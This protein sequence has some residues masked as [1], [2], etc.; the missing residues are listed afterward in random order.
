MAE[1]IYLMCFQNLR[2]FYDARDMPEAVH[3]EEIDR[4][5]EFTHVTIRRLN[6][7][8]R[9]RRTFQGILMG[10]IANMKQF[11]WGTGTILNRL[12]WAREIL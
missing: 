2:L 12:L 8:A 1:E 10:L 6:E 5:I 4:L 3:S 7:F 9:P 11:L